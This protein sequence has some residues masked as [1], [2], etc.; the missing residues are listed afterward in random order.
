[1]ECTIPWSVG[2]TRDFIAKAVD[3]LLPFD[4]ADDDWFVRSHQFGNRGPPL[5]RA[6]RPNNAALRFAQQR[7][8]VPGDALTVRQA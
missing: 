7:T 4:V 1:M 8:G 3:L 6:D 5:L 2:A